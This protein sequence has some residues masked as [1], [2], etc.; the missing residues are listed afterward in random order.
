MTGEL[1][2]DRSMHIECV[3]Y[4]YAMAMSAGNGD[5]RVEACLGCRWSSAM[6]QPGNLVCYAKLVRPC[7]SLR[8]PSARA[9][10]SCWS[11]MLRCAR[12]WQLCEEAAYVMTAQL[13]R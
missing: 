13:C 11:V 6:Q 7:P 5:N 8:V 4:I 2:H 12:M 9:N 10:S 3:G 1:S